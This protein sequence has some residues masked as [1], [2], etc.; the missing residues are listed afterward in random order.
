M[1]Q[2]IA[3]LSVFAMMVIMMSCSQEV[4]TP[5]ADPD[6]RLDSTSA[7]GRRL[8][9][10]NGYALYSFANDADGQSSCTGNCALNWQRFYVDP[11]TAVYG[12]GLTSSDFGSIEPGSGAH[13]LT[14]KGS[15]LYRFIPAGVQEPA[16]QTTGEGVG[17]VWYVA[18]PNY[19][20]TIA[21]FQL[22]D[23]AGVNYLITPPSTF[24]AGNGRSSYFCDAKGNSLYFFVRDS[25]FINKSTNASFPIYETDNIT[26]PSTLDKSLFVVINFNGKKQLTY[27]GW[28]LYYYA[29]DN[30]VRGVNK[31]FHIPATQPAGAIWPMAIRD[32]APAPRQ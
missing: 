5:V 23:A 6:I 27:K 22:T 21:N 30:S 19:S 8:V 29:P 2:N 12:D 4:L 11:A 15:P 13:Q 31:G 3:S 26:V 9:D 7:L 1:R 25:A 18:K 32:I 17:N 16:G 10:K 28:P 20:I 14:Y 24:A